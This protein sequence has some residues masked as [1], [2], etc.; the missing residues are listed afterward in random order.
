MNTRF[1]PKTSGSAGLTYSVFS[2]AGNSDSP[3]SD[4]ATVFVSVNHVF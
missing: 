4:T 1:G 3:N 2:A